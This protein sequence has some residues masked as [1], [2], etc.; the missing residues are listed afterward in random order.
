[1]VMPFMLD[2]LELGYIDVVR[3]P[4]RV[5]CVDIASLEAWMWSRN[6]HDPHNVSNLLKTH[7]N[8]VIMPSQRLNQK[9]GKQ[10]QEELQVCK[11][12]LYRSSYRSSKKWSDVEFSYSL[13]VELKGVKPRASNVNE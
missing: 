13:T 1:V 2:V 4:T 3:I 8:T 9:L 11:Y 10:M 5:H 12:F 7:Q 6:G